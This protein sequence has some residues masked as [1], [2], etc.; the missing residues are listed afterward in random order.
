MENK[1]KAI[2]SSMGHKA[3]HGSALILQIARTF[4][5]LTHK[6]GDGRSPGKVRCDVTVEYASACQATAVKR[7]SALAHRSLPDRWNVGPRMAG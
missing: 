4:P 7:S 1:G 6:G 3:D 2:G 5:H